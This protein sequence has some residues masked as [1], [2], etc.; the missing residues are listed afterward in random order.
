[1]IR[2]ATTLIISLLFLFSLSSCNWDVW[3][4]EFQDY[5]EGS[6]S[7][8]ASTLFTGAKPEE[9]SATKSRFSD[10]VR[11]SW[12]RV[13]GADY[14]EIFKNNPM[15]PLFVVREIHR[16]VNYIIDTVRSSPA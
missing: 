6:A 9:I 16:D 12:N 10:E 2:K 3:G 14:Y 8:G 15:L 7:V 11:I 4:G 1:M 5:G 13:K